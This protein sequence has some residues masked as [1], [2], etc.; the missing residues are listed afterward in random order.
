MAELQ[1]RAEDKLGLLSDVMV[2]ITQAGLPLVS[3][4]AK[5]EKNN[6]ASINLQVKIDDI[7]QLRILIEK[8]KALK[9]ILDV[10]RVNN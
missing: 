9:G 8:I 7:E 10:Y 5:T 1:V 6:T 2:I 4:N 3:L